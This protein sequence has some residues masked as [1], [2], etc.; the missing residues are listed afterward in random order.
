MSNNLRYF[1]KYD[2]LFLVLSLL[3]TVSLAIFLYYLGKTHETNCSYYAEHS[4]QI[5]LEAVTLLAASLT[6]YTN[7]KLWLTDVV[8]PTNAK[9]LKVILGSGLLFLSV[10]FIGFMF[11]FGLFF[12]KHCYS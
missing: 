2:R 4:S 5:A 11:E 1:L 10:G 9:L 3:T 6:A 7:A 12:G 8:K